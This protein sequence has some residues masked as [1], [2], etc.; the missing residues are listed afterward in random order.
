MPALDN[1]RV[2]VWDLTDAAAR[3]GRHYHP[4]DAVVAWIDGSG[5]HARWI[6]RGTAHDDEGVGAAT[7]V[8]MFE[9]K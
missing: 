7:R 4:Q 5:A 2:T 1:E 6:P 3:P 9:L 8:T